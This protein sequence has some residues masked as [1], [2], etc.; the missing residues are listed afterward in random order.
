[1]LLSSNVVEGEGT[2]G[3]LR[4]GSGTSSNGNSGVVNLRSGDGEGATGGRLTLCVGTA[5]GGSAGDLCVAAGDTSARTR[6]SG[7]EIALCCP[8]GGDRDE[9][10]AL[11]LVGGPGYPGGDVSHQRRV[12]IWNLSRVA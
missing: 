7:G 6:A 4:F 12:S 10:G 2:S 8:S 5:R 3:M 11:T 1:M 9:G